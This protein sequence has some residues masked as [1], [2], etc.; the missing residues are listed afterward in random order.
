[1]NTASTP[2]PAILLRSSSTIGSI[3]GAPRPDAVTGTG[4]VTANVTAAD[5]AAPKVFFLALVIGWS[6]D[7]SLRFP[8]AGPSRANHCVAAIRF[9][10]GAT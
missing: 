10:F 9:D 3:T 7:G 5:A 8:L 4:H 1:M 6:L 2:Q